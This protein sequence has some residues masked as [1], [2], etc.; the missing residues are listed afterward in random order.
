MNLIA[1]VIDGHQVD[2]RPPSSATEG[3]ARH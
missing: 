1:H 3:E 2:I